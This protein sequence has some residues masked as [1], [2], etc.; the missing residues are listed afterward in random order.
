M[1]VRGLVEYLA[2]EGKVYLATL[3]RLVPW[4]NFKPLET[5]TAVVNIKR[6][7]FDAA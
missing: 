7:K 4:L 6:K 2:M 3:K 1:S 5:E